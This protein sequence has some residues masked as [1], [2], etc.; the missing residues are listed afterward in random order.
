MATTISRDTEDRQ[1]VLPFFDA[2]TRADDGLR[3][4]SDEAFI[5]PMVDTNKLEIIAYGEEAGSLISN[6]EKW[7]R[8][9]ENRQKIGTRH[10]ALRSRRKIQPMNYRAA[11]H[12]ELIQSPLPIAGAVSR[13][14][15]SVVIPE[16][17]RGI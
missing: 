7:R 6:Q 17:T 15:P 16:R 2:N 10:L 5:F 12:V 4:P 1:I 11:S 9:I 14:Y 3:A 13:F 8:I